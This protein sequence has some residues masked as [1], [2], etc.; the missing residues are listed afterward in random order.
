M[1]HEKLLFVEPVVDF[2]PFPR[3][4]QEKC[5]ACVKGWF[6]GQISLEPPRASRCAVSRAEAPR[7]VF[8]S[9]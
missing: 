8:V 6:F 4:C 1:K 5:Q 9:F 7:Q 2:G 3:H